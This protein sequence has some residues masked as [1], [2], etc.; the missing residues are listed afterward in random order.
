MV[1]W[2][3]RN[4]NGVNVAHLFSALKQ[5]ISCRFPP[6]RR[7]GSISARFHF[8]I[9]SSGAVGSA[10]GSFLTAFN[11]HLKPSTPFIGY[12]PAGFDTQSVKMTSF[13]LTSR[14]LFLINAVTA[15]W[16]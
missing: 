16:I 14:C 1:F 13:C 11:I 2:C 6:T 8:E 10:D 15:H 7:P 9:S 3:S 4:T 12:D 5:K